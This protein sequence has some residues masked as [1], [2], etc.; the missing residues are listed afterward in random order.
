[1]KRSAVFK[2]L[3]QAAKAA[4]K[5]FYL[6]E[7]TRHTNVTIGQTTSRL[8]RHSEIDDGAAHSFFDQFANE[9]GKGW[10]R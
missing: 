2:K 9:L 4:G 1:M 6:E 8:G 5:E 10:W 3:K 7:R